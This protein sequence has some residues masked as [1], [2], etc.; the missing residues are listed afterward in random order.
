MLD[1]LRQKW[2][3]TRWRWLVICLALFLLGACTH[4]PE[5]PAETD[6]GYA[7]CWPCALYEI[8]FQAMDKAME[9]LIKSAC[10]YA[11]TFLGLGLLF[12]IMFHAAK[13]ILTPMREPNVREFLFPLAKVLFK[14]MVVSA[15]IYNGD[16]YIELIGQTIVQPVLVLFADLS[17]MILDA[18]ATVKDAT[19]VASQAANMADAGALFGAEAEGKYLDIVFRLYLALKLGMDLGFLIWRDSGIVPFLFG[20]FVICIFWVLLVT[21]PLSFLDAFVRI[22]VL[23]ILSPFCLVG[24]VFPAT[25]GLLKKLWGVLLG[26]G[27]TVLFTC[28]YLA[29]A[30]YVILASAEKNYPGILG[31]ALQSTDPYLSASVQSMSSSLIGFFVV[32]LSMGRFARHVPKIANALGGETVN[33]SW[34]AA[35]NSFKKSDHIHPHI[36]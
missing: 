2:V 11:M 29:I 20:L 16:A 23:L 27:M 30:I 33:A 32:V 3:G 5:E 14:A 22:G 21:L 9:T 35:F 24:W 12:W 28:I 10:G 6:Q 4:N 17:T 8:T 26:A 31:D 18:N 36:V 13:T 34:Y 19:Q 1:R 25:G 7:A 15:I